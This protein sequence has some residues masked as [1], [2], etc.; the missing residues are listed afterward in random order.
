MYFSHGSNHSKGVFILIRDNLDFQLNSIKYD[1]NGRY[2]F[3]QASVQDSSFLF[4][5]IY[6]PNKENEQCIFFQNLNNLLIEELSS[7]I[8]PHIIVGGDFNV[9]SNTDLDCSGSK[10]T[11]K[12]SAKNIDDI[13]LTFDLVD[14]WRL[15]N[16]D[17]KTFSWRQKSPIIQRRLD[18]WLI[19]D[20][21]QEDIDT[22]DIIP[23]IKTDHS[24]ITLKLNSIPEQKVGP[25]YWKFNNS[26][27]ND[28]EYTSQIENLLP[29]WL[30]E[31]EDVTDKRVLWDLIKYRI[32]QTTIKYSK[33][34]AKIRKQTL[35]DAEDKLKSADEIR[36][37]LPNE[38]NIAD[39]EKA[40]IEYET[41]FDYIVQGNVIRSRAMW[42]EKR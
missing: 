36:C 15:R 35:R 22:T 42:Y 9:F 29:K 8:E 32:R 40:K 7:N 13:K 25:S 4:V 34:K 18:Y 5:N 37:I 19:E 30:N 33:G 12:K 41:L 24:A 21:L 38:S 6:A 11:V 28:L 31:F 10:P 27:I 39:L 3:L 23:A 16:P 20:T 14:I 1:E 26:L 17:K 2:I